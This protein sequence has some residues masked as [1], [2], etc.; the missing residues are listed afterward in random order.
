MYLRG[1]FVG[2]EGL[3]YGANNKFE[4]FLHKVGPIDFFQYSRVGLY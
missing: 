2:G 1:T 4:T 3:E